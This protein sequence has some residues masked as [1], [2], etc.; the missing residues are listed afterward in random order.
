MN[1]DEYV[2]DNDSLAGEPLYR[3]SITSNQ[4]SRKRKNPPPVDTDS[5]RSKRNRHEPLPEDHNR[6]EDDS[7]PPDPHSPVENSYPHQQPAIHYSRSDAVNEPP[8]SGD[9]GLFGDMEP[10]PKWVAHI[11]K[12][13]DVEDLSKMED[14]Y[15]QDETW[16]FMC[17]YS[18]SA[19]RSDDYK[20]ITALRNIIRQNWDKAAKFPVAK[21]LQDYY[22]ERIRKTF[23]RELKN[24]PWPLKQIIYH[25]T[26]HNVDPFIQNEE[27]IQVL[28]CVVE[29]ITTHE[30]FLYDET[31][32]ANGNH[33]QKIDKTALK[34]LFECWKRLDVV[35]N[36]AASMR[37]TAL[38]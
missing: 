19:Y 10:K 3:E 37:S 30:L 20:F 6:Y 11:P 22:N 34:T 18:E 32:A 16:C 26:V 27:Q 14:E 4:S 7:E 25:F 31:P 12:Q 28:S 33:N 9:G 1:L 2:S 29:V 35:Q 17:W 5:E 15:I 13:L 8:I 23:P 38:V 36:R 21:A 24:R